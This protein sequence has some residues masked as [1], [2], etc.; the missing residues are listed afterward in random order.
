MLVALMGFRGY[1]ISKVYVQLCALPTGSV[2]LASSFFAT[3]SL[4][5]AARWHPPRS[6]LF[7]NLCRG[8]FW[9]KR[10]QTVGM[11]IPFCKF[12]APVKF[13]E[14][15]MFQLSCKQNNAQHFL[16]VWSVV[17]LGST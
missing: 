3:S 5:V 8:D 9:A 1:G 10:P 12:C 17:Y 2:L 16:M 15:P 6:T 7:P 14:F 4:I 13:H 11:A